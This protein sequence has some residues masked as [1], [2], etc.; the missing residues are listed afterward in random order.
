[1]SNEIEV[2]I[3][4]ESLVSFMKQYCFSTG[5]GLGY[6]Y[7]ARETGEICKFQRYVQ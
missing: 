5:D 1:M 7:L 6:L 3:F 2:D 4:V